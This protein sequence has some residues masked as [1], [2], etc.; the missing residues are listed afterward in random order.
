M[1]VEHPGGECW[2]IR[3]SQCLWDGVRENDACTFTLQ[4]HFLGAASLRTALAAR[5]EVQW[6]IRLLLGLQ[7]DRSIKRLD[8]RRKGAAS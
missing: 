8:C 1:K 5:R 3:V 6:L 7:S 2:V 4:H